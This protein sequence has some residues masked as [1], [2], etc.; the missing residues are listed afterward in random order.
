MNWQVVFYIDGEGNEPIKDFILGQT[1]GAIAENDKHLAM[2][3][4]NDYKSRS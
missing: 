4:M 3:R 1:D 2:Q